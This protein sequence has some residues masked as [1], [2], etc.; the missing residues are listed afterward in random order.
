MDVSAKGATMLPL[1]EHVAEIPGESKVGLYN[2]ETG[3]IKNEIVADVE[4][5]KSINVPVGVVDTS[6]L[7]V[8]LEDYFDD[9]DMIELCKAIGVNEKLLGYGNKSDK[10]DN[11]VSFAEKIGYVGCLLQE[12]FMMF[13]NRR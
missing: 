7:R 6:K 3:T 8:V 11:L 12:A 13:K 2:F 4:K 9:V 5:P 1:I 10:V